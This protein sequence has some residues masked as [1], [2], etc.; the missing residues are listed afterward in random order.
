[1][2]L[3]INGHNRTLT[4]DIFKK[5]I[6]FNKCMHHKTGNYFLNIQSFQYFFG[7]Y[8]LW[9]SKN[10]DILEVNQDDGILKYCYKDDRYWLIR[11]GILINTIL[12]EFTGVYPDS[13]AP[14]YENGFVIAVFD[15]SLK[16]FEIMQFANE[17]TSFKFIKEKPII[18]EEFDEL[19]INESE[20]EDNFNQIEN[21]EHVAPVIKTKTVAEAFDTDDCD[22][23]CEKVCYYNK[24]GICQY[25]DYKMEVNSTKEEDEHPHT[26]V[27]PLEEFEN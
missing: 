5:K 27:E 26:C 1:M 3:Y 21:N 24:D 15:N 16:F 25:F 13:I 19:D 4:H 11:D 14:H 20:D 23:K 12:E 2:K 8:D 17:A 6:L 18:S 9:N 10:G 22:L 7:R